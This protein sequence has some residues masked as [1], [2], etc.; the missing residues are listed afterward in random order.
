MAEAAIGGAAFMQMEHERHNMPC[1]SSKP[2]ESLLTVR[3][4]W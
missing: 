1:F 3:S 2:R 4:A